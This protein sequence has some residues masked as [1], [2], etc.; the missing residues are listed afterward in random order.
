LYKNKNVLTTISLRSA[1]NA[2][3][4]LNESIACEDSFLFALQNIVISNIGLINLAQRLGLAKESLYK[5]LSP[6]GNPSFRLICSILRELGAELL[7]S[8]ITF[9]SRETVLPAIRSNSVASMYPDLS[10]EWHP[11]KNGNLTANDIMPGNRKKFWWLNADGKEWK[12]SS[13]SRISK[14][15]KGLK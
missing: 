6:K 1:K 10:K 13:N 14:I 7:I 4:L 9:V 15:F 11:S 2:K 5:S 8:R 12:E 3:K